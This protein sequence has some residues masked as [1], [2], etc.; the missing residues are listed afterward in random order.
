MTNNTEGFG[1]VF[2]ELDEDGLAKKVA[3]EEHS[4][5]DL[6]LVQMARKVCMAKGG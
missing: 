4:V 6:L 5:T 3:A 1:A 2:A